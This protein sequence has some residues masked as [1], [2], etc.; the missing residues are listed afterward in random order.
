MGRGGG[1]GERVEE[2]AT[3]EGE[4][5]RRKKGRRRERESKVGW[6]FKVKIL[7]AGFFGFFFHISPCFSIDIA[8]IIVSSLSPPFPPVPSASPSFHSVIIAV[9]VS[10]L[11]KEIVRS[12]FEREKDLIFE[13]FLTFLKV[14]IYK[15]KP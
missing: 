12:E 13:S 3:K 5:E 14:I 15:F 9:E 6:A 1:G 10:D 11:R 7:H 8:V 4:G 2:G